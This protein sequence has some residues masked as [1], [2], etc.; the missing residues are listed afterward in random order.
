V[1]G[2]RRDDNARR[3]VYGGFDARNVS[4]GRDGKR[5]KFGGHGGHQRGEQSATT[6]TAATA[7]ATAAAAAA[8]AARATGD[9]E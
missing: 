2:D 8:T 7:T 1:D 9:G 5:R 6:T 3:V 4:V